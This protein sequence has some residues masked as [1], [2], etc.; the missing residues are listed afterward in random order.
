MNFKPIQEFSMRHLLIALSLLLV[1]PW[2]H[3]Q[4]FEEGVHYR[5]IMEQQSTQTGDKVEVREL[6]WY[7]CPHCYALHGPMEA[8]K[9]AMPA[10][11]EYVAMPAVL[12]ESWEFHAR[13]FYTLVALGIQEEFNEALFDAIHK[14]PRP[15]NRVFDPQ[16]VAQWLEDAGGP[17]SA[18]FMNAFQSFAVDTQTR[19]AVLMTR[20]Y[21][22]SGVPSVVVDGRFVTTVTM[23]GNYDTFFKVIEHLVDI[24]SAQ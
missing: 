21:D 18:E 17:P 3:A 23:A 10:N 12:G 7:H 9:G 2:I 20:L 16:R 15:L 13:V 11:A 4:N 14:A 5:E 24:A 6:F 8:W 22:I 19:N 1:S